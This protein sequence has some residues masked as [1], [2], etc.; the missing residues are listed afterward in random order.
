MTFTPTPADKFTFGLWTVGNRGRDPFGELRPAAARSGDGGAPPR[1]AR[2]LGRELPRQR[3][4]AHR[5]HR[6][7]A[8]PHRPRLPRGRSTAT[9]VTVPMATTNLFTDPVFKDGAF[10]SHDAGCAATRCRRRC[11]PW[12]WASSWAHAPTSSGAAAR[13]PKWTRARTRS[14]RSS[15]SA[16]PS[17]TCAST[18]ATS[19]TTC[20]SRSR[21]SRTSRAATSTSRPPRAYLGFIAHPGASGHGRRQPRVRPRADGRPQLLPRG[22]AG[23]RGRQAVSHRSQRSEAGPLRSGSAL[24]IGIDQAAVLPGEAARG[25]AATTARATSTPTPTGPRTKTACGTSRAAACAPT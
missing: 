14:R 24:R 13:A 15:A 23:A 11:A 3:P 10:T 4:G 1:R 20:A 22:R 7:R 19:A 25:V 8:R 18:R 5:R 9:G 6:R 2:R 12:T 17:T 21:P 16:T